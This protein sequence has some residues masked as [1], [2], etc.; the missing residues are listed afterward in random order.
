[1]R[2]GLEGLLRIEGGVEARGGVARRKVVGVER[3]FPAHGIEVGHAHRVAGGREAVD[4]EAVQ[5][6]V[7]R[8]C[9]GMGEDEQ[10][11]HD[12]WKVRV[13]MPSG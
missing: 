3:G 2:A 8:S 9:F 10:D 6:A 7:E 4:H 12:F 5:C 11:V 1:L 13:E